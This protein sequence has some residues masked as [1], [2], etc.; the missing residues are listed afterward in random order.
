MP[1]Q[2]ALTQRLGLDYPIIQAPLAGGGDTRIWSLPSARRELS[3]LLEQP[4]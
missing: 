2:T 4:I 1:F 3:V